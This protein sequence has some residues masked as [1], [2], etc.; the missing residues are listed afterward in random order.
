MG[1]TLL[2]EAGGCYI[3]AMKTSTGLKDIITPKQSN[4]TKIHYK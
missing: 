2:T 1:K 3:T 4:L